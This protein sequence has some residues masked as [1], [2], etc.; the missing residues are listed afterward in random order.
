MTFPTGSSGGAFRARRADHVAIAQFVNADDLVLDV[1]CGTG[2]LTE[3][4][5]DH[6]AAVTAVDYSEAYADHTRERLAGRA[7]VEQ[8]D[9]RSLRFA[10]GAFDAARASLVLDTIPEADRAVAEM[11]R[12]V[13]PG[14]TGAAAVF[15]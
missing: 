13:R 3:A 7:T 1:G 9:A 11:R 12:V 2:T 15:D 5:A 4:L 14:G 8:G 10:D 6:G